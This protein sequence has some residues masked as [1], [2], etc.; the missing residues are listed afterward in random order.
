MKVGF[1]GSR[2]GTTTAQ[3]HTLRSFLIENLNE[4]EEFHHGC[5]VGADTMA[6]NVAYELGI[7]ISYH[8]PTDM[9]Q[10]SDLSEFDGTWFRPKPY[11]ER[12]REI[13]DCCT[14]L[15]AMPRTDY[16]QQRGG[17]WYTVRYARKKDKIVNILRRGGGW[18]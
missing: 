6:H 10:A 9:S 8:P 12:N 2:S 5:C 13:V 16:E 4:I 18:L 15:I 17:T 3:L 14:V 7:P 11:L 1:T